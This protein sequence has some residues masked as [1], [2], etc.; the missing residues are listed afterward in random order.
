[1]LTYI[2]DEV[3]ERVV[4]HPIVVVYELGRIWSVRIEIKELG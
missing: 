1:M 3:K 2:S 4:F